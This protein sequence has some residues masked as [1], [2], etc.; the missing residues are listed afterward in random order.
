MMHCILY[1]TGLDNASNIKTWAKKTLI[2]YY[3]KNGKKTF[4]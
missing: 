2:S 3:K 4:Q 1:Y